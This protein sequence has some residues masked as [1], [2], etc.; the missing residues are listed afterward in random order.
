MLQ[1]DAVLLC[2]GRGGACVARPAGRPQ[3]PPW[4]LIDRH[5][6]C[7]VGGTA[8]HEAKAGRET[9]SSRARLDSTSST[10]V[11][12]AHTRK[13]LRHAGTEIRIRATCA[14]KPRPE[15]FMAD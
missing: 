12:A 6:G 2:A 13:P 14:H 15:W 9:S 3:T 11:S 7:E 4:A 1:A 10:A 8:H 5:C